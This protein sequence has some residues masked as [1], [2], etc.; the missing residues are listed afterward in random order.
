MRHMLAGQ[1]LGVTIGRAGQVIDQGEWDIVF[2]RSFITEYNLY[3]RGGNNLFPI[4]LYPDTSKTTLFDTELHTDAPGGRHPNL[5]STFLTDCSRRLDMEFIPD[6]KGDLY[7]TFGPED[8]LHYMYA[9]FYS[10]SYRNRYA[11]FLKIDFPRLPLTTNANL[12]RALCE[13]GERLV[14][15][16][17]IE[18]FGKALPAYPTEGNNIVEKIEYVEIQD[19]P[20]Q[21]RV[22]INKA[23]CFD[24]IPSEVWEFHIGGYQV[25]EKWLK[26]RKGQ[27]L[28]FN[29]IKHY[30]RIVAALKETTTLMEQID[31]MIEKHG[32]W[33]IE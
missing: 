30:Q 25:C 8:I 19:Q 1:N 21:G 9:I 17:L 20:E 4:Y 11:A 31:E 12:F 26:D 6:G 28:S 13:R 7:K 5:A 15:L 16:H 23:Q 10:S 32:G 22:Y 18:Q 3:R 29:D 2:C 14:R 24:S 27:V 33:P